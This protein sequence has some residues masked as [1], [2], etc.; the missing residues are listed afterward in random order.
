MVMSGFRVSLEDV[1]LT[2]VKG[3]AP[4]AN[5]QALVGA[6]HYWYQSSLLTFDADFF[7]GL[8]FSILL[9]STTA[10]QPASL[11]FEFDPDFFVMPI[12]W[13]NSITMECVIGEKLHFKTLQ[14]NLFNTSSYS[15]DL[16]ISSD[17]MESMVLLFNRKWFDPYARFCP[18]LEAVL[19]PC[20]EAQCCSLMQ[21]AQF[22][23]I[24]Q[25]SLINRIRAYEQAPALAGNYYNS[26]LT[27]F[28]IS[29]VKQVNS[30]LDA[31]ACDPF[32]LE[33][34]AKVRDIIL[35]DFEIYHT[36]EALAKM[37]RMAEMKLQLA[38]K[39]LYGTTVMNFSRDARLEKGFEL[40]TT[41]D[42]PLRVVCMMVGYD[43]PSNFSC[44]F[45]KKYGYW[46]GYI[47]KSAKQSS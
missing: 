24:D 46:P 27:V 6:A 31:G 13:N 15:A 40:L 38:F 7:G 43:D 9:L 44:A 11:Q 29:M 3:M 47:R 26:L 37:V 32:E 8:D 5:R 34:A 35:K 12:A 19:G 4:S 30:L 21:T 41:T 28:M 23:S 22:L 2:L 18:R 36:V 45:K 14:Y 16:S 17:P 10:G 25:V 33:K 1:E 42:Y 39:Q 20:V